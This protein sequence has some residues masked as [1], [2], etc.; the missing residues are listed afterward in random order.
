[1]PQT[2]H[3]FY[4]PGDVDYMKFGV[5]API[6]YTIWT[7]KSWE[8]RDTIL[9]LYDT[10]H[11]TVLK[12]NDESEIDPANWPFSGFI[13]HFEEAGTYFLKVEEAFSQGGCEPR[14]LYTIAISTTTSLSSPMPERVA[15]LTPRLQTMYKR[16]GI[17]LPLY[18]KER[19]GLR[20]FRP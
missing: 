16:T 9:T 11:N 1:V 7:T 17:F 10:D 19:D 14:Y 15:H 3:Y 12:E 6:T 20:R 4:T 13:Y 18:W 2:D 8:V 5:G